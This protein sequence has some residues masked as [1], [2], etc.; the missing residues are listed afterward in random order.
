MKEVCDLLQQVHNVSYKYWKDET[1]VHG[2]DIGEVY[3][4]Y[5]RLIDVDPW[6]EPEEFDNKIR[7]SKKSHN[8]TLVIQQG[9]FYLPP[10][11][12]ESD[13]VATLSI[14]SNLQTGKM[15]LH[16]EMHRLVEGS[17][18]GI[19]Y[20]LE[21]GTGEHAHYHSSLLIRRPGAQ[22]GVLLSGCP[23]WLPTDIPRIPMKAT[24]PV[25]L[26]ICAILSLYG[27]KTLRILLGGLENVRR[28]YLA[29][30][31]EIL[32]ER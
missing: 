10:L 18:C 29:D 19:G 31:E 11:D 4:T 12:E 2:D 13:F 28:K 30:L 26:V 15:N 23:P 3:D 22:G 5:L 20:R 9:T 25:S 24:N 6:I 16:I 1:D 17:L 8:S 7:E 27:R 14:D 21:I 32:K